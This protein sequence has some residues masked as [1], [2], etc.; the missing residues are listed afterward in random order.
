MNVTMNPV[1]NVAVV[2]I[3]GRIDASN[4]KDFK[5]KF[6]SYLENYTHFVFDM[7]ELEFLDSTGLGAVISSLKNASEAGGDIAIA[8]LQP[9]PK[10]LFEI[11]R[12]HKIFSVHDDVESAIKSFQG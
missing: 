12:A 1:G 8:N 9:K 7:T 2:E 5:E 6:Q 4:S 11:T 3:S 10:M